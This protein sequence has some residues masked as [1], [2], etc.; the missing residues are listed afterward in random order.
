MPERMLAILSNYMSIC[1]DTNLFSGWT[2]E[3]L[4]GDTRQHV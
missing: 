4:S 1:D 3:K 2:Q